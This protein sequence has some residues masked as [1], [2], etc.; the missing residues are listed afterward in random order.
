MIAHDMTM[1]VLDYI[2]TS[3]VFKQRPGKSS[4]KHFDIVA[5]VCS[6]NKRGNTDIEC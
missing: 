1:R 3:H 2:D 6:F 5:K 4:H